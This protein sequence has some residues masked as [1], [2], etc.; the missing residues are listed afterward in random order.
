MADGTDAQKLRELEDRAD[1]ADRRVT[2]LEQK[3]VSSEVFLLLPA[4]KV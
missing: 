2:A 1:E 4:N 3:H